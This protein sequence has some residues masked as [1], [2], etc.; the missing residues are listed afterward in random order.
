MRTLIEDLHGSTYK[1]G[2]YKLSAFL[3]REFIGKGR[4][5]LT[6]DTLGNDSFIL[7]KRE[8]TTFGYIFYANYIYVYGELTFIK[9]N[10]NKD[11]RWQEK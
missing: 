3:P 6:R 9:Y 1:V 2:S 8:D 4:I 11:I 10:K 7:V 5:I